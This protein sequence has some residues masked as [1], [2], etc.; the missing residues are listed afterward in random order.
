[1][2]EVAVI[3]IGDTKFGEL[4]DLSFREIG[5]Q[6]GL[7]QSMMLIFLVRRSMLCMSAICGWK[8]HRS[9]TYWGAHCRLLGPCKE[10]IPGNKG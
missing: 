2:K 5:I 8:V 10:Y 4:W 6:A 7:A 1:M 9:R 3:G